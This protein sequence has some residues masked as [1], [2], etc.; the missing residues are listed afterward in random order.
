LKESG[1]PKIEPFRTVFG[2]ANGIET[3]P[4]AAAKTSMLKDQQW[5]DL[6][7]HRFLD[8]MTMWRF[9]RATV[10]AVKF[11]EFEDT[12]GPFPFLSELRN[13]L[14]CGRCAGRVFRISTNNFVV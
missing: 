2:P 10:L 11:F 3:I 8:A 12:D 4:D 9:V 6:P 7:S 5:F 1:P 13:G 14:G